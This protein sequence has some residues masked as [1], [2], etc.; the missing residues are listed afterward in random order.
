MEYRLKV[1][2]LTK[3]I[4]NNLILDDVSF[5]LEKGKIYGLVGA[6]G[7]GKSTLIKAILGLTSFKG[8]ISICGFSIRKKFSRAIRNVSAI[9]D[10]VS[11]YDYLT[12]EENLR[13]FALLY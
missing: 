9:V 1:D 5:K 10:Y 2:H 4:N 3:K 8:N 7:S 6:N 12:A 13:Y 11:F